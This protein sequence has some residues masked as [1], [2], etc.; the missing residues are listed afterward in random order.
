MTRYRPPRNVFLIGLTSFFNDMSNE[1]VLAIFPAFFTSVL[2]AGAGSLGL[3]EGLADGTANIIKIHAGKYSDKIKKRKPFMIFGYGLSVAT[4]PLY[5]LVS[6][7]AGVVGIR[8]TDRIGKGLREAPRDAIISLSTPKEEMGRAFGFHRMLDT[9]GAI[10]GPLI[11]YLILRAYP[12]GFNIVFVVAFIIGLI[13]V[14]SIFF[15]KDI[16]GEARKGNI[17]LRL[18]GAFNINFKKYL[19]ALF[20]LSAGSIPVAVLLLKTQHL[21]FSLA[22]IPLFYMLY[23]LSY[24]G[25]SV[26]AGGMSDRIGARTVMRIGY[27]VLLIGYFVVALASGAITLALGFLLLGLFPALTDGVARAL[28]AELSPEDHRAGAYGLV[29]ATAGFGLMFAGIAGGY[30]WEHFGANYALL[31]GGVLVVVGIIVLSTVIANGKENLGS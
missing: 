11:A 18:L 3:V 8:V 21:G 5:L 15:I 28:A 22:S 25:F 30:I 16:V 10:L 24:A 12:E 6:S 26:S 17:P 1:M 23:N 19:V 9:L 2:K 13:A 7:V 20:L 31:V 27:A 14:A 29:N 4:R